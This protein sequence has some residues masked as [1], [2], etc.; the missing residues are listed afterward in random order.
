MGGNLL[1][2]FELVLVF[3]LLIGFGFWQLRE[4]RRLRED[5][6]RRERENRDS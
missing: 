4:L 6:E 2:L 5:R 3:G 1:I